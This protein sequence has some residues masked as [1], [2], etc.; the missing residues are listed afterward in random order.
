MINGTV[1][2]FV[3]SLVARLSASVNSSG[4]LAAVEPSVTGVRS[5]VSNGTPKT[6]SF[7]TG[8]ASSSP[9]SRSPGSPASRSDPIFSSSSVGV[10]GTLPG[11]WVLVSTMRPNSSSA[12]VEG[13]KL[14]RVTMLVSWSP[15]PKS[16]TFVVNA[17][18]ISVFMVDSST[19]SDPVPDLVIVVVVVVVVVNCTFS[20]NV[21]VIVVCAGGAVVVG[22][23]LNKFGRNIPENPVD[24]V[25]PVVMS[26]ASF[27]V[28]VVV[29]VV[30]VVEVKVVVVVDVLVVVDS[31]LIPKFSSKSVSDTM[32]ISVVVPELSEENPNSSSSITESF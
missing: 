13:K 26:V 1:E 23:K 10:L 5:E 30:E 25:L 31:R 17:L 14:G 28:V 15:T 24:I 29:V 3:G 11:S 16:S 19:A 7:P 18:I 2:P 6:S 22:A 32:T 20:G 12:S 4:I 21:V 9:P 27:V 8:S